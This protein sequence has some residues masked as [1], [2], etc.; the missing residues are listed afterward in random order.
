MNEEN[1]IIEKLKQMEKTQ[2]NH[3]F[4]GLFLA[5]VLSILVNI[6]VKEK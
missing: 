1:I 6:Y 5:T 2:I 4:W 3:F